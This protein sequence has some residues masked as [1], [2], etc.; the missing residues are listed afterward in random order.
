MFSLLVLELKDF[1]E[2]YTAETVGA[3]EM[4]GVPARI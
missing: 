1:D 4:R 2:P 3:A